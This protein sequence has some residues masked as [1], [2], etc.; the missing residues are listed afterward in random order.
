MKSEVYIGP[1]QGP[2]GLFAG[3]VYQPNRERQEPT[4]FSE[5][6]ERVFDA[7]LGCWVKAEPQPLPGKRPGLAATPQNDGSGVWWEIRERD[8]QLLWTVEAADFDRALAEKR[9]LCHVVGGRS[10]WAFIS[11]IKE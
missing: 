4:R 8:G 6:G 1:P 9:R 3:R 11:R 7:Y 2:R 10:G 5:D